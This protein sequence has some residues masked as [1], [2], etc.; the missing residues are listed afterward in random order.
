[1]TIFSKAAI[2]ATVVG[3]AGLAQAA[4]IDPQYHGEW[5]RAVLKTGET[6]PQAAGCLRTKLGSMVNSMSVS[7]AQ[8]VF[9]ST[10]YF[11]NEEC[12]GDNY[13]HSVYI[14]SF[15]GFLRTKTSHIL[16][17]A[18]QSYE[19]KV[20]GA[21]TVAKL[22]D[23]KVC[24]HSEWTEKTY[25]SGGKV[26]Q[27]CTFDNMGLTVPPFINDEQLKDWRTR[28]SV[29]GTGIAVASTHKPGGEFHHTSYYVKAED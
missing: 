14:Y 15:T 25:S 19:L 2:A 10:N 3:L 6:D 16:K 1:M 9:T 29:Q 13:I 21:D 4:E 8:G 23:K 20:V 27:A 12:K 5:Q 28:Y 11:G 7:G 17:V 24:G 26:L 18:S 22:N